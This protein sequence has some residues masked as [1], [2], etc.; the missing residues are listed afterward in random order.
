[1][2]FTSDARQ[3]I[4][5]TPAGL[6]LPPGRWAVSTAFHGLLNDNW[7]AAR[8]AD[9][10]RLLTRFLRTYPVE[11]REYYKVEEGVVRI[12]N[13]FT[14]DRWGRSDWQAPDY[15]PIPPIYSWGRDS[16]G[17]TGIPSGAGVSP[18]SVASP[19]G[20]SNSTDI[21][22]PVGPWRWQNGKTLS[23]ELTRYAAP[24]AAFPRRPSSKT[25]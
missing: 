25:P 9:R 12:F 15:A 1:M 7:D 23:Y 3:P 14:Y 17:W 11:C 16:L 18:A 8:L 2:L 24:H 5:W 20:A 19:R 13:E 21:Y 4:E 22:T 6:R 10:A